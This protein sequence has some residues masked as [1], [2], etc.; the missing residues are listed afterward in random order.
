VYTN[1]LEMGQELANGTRRDIHTQAFF[2][3]GHVF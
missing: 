1:A 3:L 2:I